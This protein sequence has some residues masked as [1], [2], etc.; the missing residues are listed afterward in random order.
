MSNRQQK[1]LLITKTLV[2]PA[3]EN[4]LFS[5]IGIVT[6]INIKMLK[7]AYFADFWL[8]LV[9]FSAFLI[10]KPYFAVQSKT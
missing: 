2:P 10:K 4:L 6:Y 8:C 3:C 9:S 5:Y 1:A 7:V